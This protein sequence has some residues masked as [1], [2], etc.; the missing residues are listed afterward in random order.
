MESHQGIFFVGLTCPFFFDPSPS[1]PHKPIRTQGLPQGP[2]PQVEDGP[3][4][5]DADEADE[6]I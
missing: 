4:I 5:D 3:K 2:V 6:A 1:H